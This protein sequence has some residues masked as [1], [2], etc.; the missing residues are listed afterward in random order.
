VRPI[1]AEP[2]KKAEARVLVVD[3]VADNREMYAEYLRF[4]GFNVATAVDAEEALEMVHSFAP[5][6]VVMDL[7]LPRVSGWVA[8]SRIKED[9]RTAH[10]RVLALS[11]HSLREHIDGAMAAGADAYCTKP[12]LPAALLTTIL[13]LLPPGLAPWPAP[14]TG[15]RR[16]PIPSG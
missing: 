14:S 5:H 2:S 16:R 3:D 7:A 13:S 10:I 4:A 11:G 9:P 8:T 12:C 1:D 6:V 15:T